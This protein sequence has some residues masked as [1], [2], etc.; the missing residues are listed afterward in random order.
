MIR[1]LIYSKRVVKKSLSPFNSGDKMWI[2]SSNPDA[3][4]LKKICKLTGIYVSDLQKSL[5]QESLPRIINRKG[6]SMI[7]LRALGPKR[8][9][10]PFG[11]FISNKMI[12]TVHKKK[13]CA[14]EDL[15]ELLGGKEGKEFF[16][17]GLTYLFF[18]ISSY[19]N[20]RY[21]TEL[22]RLE[23]EIDQLEDDI[24]DGKMDKPSKI[25]DLKGKVMHLRRALNTNRN[26][27]D[28]ISGGY[29]KYIKEKN[30]NW[31]SELKIETDQVVSITELLR[32][33]LT[34]AMEM[35][36]SSVS[37]KLNDIMRG[38][39]VVASLLLLPMLI[40]GIWGMNFANIPFFDSQFGFDIP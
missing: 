4:E 30:N 22:D 5:D 36:M 31:L 37:N 27:V 16:S 7:I 35:Y 26:L 29:S 1:S 10:T 6:Y 11:I 34:G 33:R 25:F 18:R 21:H 17:N 8:R 13:I 14:L 39:T 23:D 24:L 19:V 12:V 3:L 32:E 15:Y 2:D 38:F 28:L 9:Y 20:K 40:S